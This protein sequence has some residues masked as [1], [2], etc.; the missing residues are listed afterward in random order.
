MSFTKKIKAGL[1]QASGYL[2]LLIQQIPPLGVYPA[3]MTLPLF[4]YLS[5]LFS[6]IPMN[7]PYAIIE[8]FQMGIFLYPIEIALTVGGITLA[9]GSTLYLYRHRNQGLVTSGPYRYIRH[10]QYTGFILLSLGLTVISYK[11]L[12]STFGIGW[13]SPEATIALWFGQFAVYIILALIEDSYLSKTYG[14]S[15]AEYKQ[16]TAFLLPLGKLGHLNLPVSILILSSVL[17]GLIML[18]IPVLYLA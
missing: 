6:Q 14:E 9:I 15:Y 12:T 16:N 13:L 8:F 3:L 5:I 4:L 11:I 7:I 18:G 2:V 1:L 10:P 17:F